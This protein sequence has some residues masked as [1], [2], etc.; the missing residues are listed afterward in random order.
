MPASTYLSDSEI[1]S[2]TLSP[3]EKVKE[4]LSELSLRTNTNW[5]IRPRTS[6]I[7]RLFRR[8]LFITTYSLL[9]DLGMNEFQLI[10]FPGEQ[11]GFNFSVPLH[12]LETFLLGFLSGMEFSK[13]P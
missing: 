12:Q 11:E 8:A 3:P 2:L 9:C 1:S 7:P 13:T 6:S 4:L 5:L 10:N